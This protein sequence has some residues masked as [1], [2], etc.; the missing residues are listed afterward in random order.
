MLKESIKITIPSTIHDQ[1]A[2]VELIDNMREM[3]SCEMAKMFGGF[4]ET[5]GRGGYYSAE[6]DKLIVENVY[7]IE[8]K[9]MHISAADRVNIA[10][11]AKAIKDTMKQECIA[12]E[13]NGSMDFV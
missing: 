4:T 10:K 12:I 7:I 1:P 8:S 9:A 13:I 5:C 11:L 3:V 6:L 2:A